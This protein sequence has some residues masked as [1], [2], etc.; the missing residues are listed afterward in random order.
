MLLRAFIFWLL[1]RLSTW[2]SP[3]W[4]TMN[5]RSVT[6]TDLW[7][8]EEGSYQHQQQTRP[9]SLA[10]ALTDSPVGLLAWILEKYRNWSDN[11]GILSRRF[12]DDFL[13]T[14]ASLYWFT[15]SISTSLR[16]YF[17]YAHGI[18]GRVSQVA[19]PTAV[20]VFPA[21]LARPPRRWAERTY[22]VERYT[23][24]PAGGHFAPYEEPG[25]LAEDIAQFFARIVAGR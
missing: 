3:L 21:D 18:T 25:L 6:S 19:V 16:P 1:H 10:P 22:S 15:N 23:V 9:L 7:N 8:L 20:A 24:M 17:E 12:G 5:R 13:L 4:M 14:Q 11:G 2:T